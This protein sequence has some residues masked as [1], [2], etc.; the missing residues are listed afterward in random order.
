VKVFVGGNVVHT[1]QFFFPAAVTNA[2]ARRRPYS[3]HGRPDTPNAS[4]SIFRNGGS[5]SM[6]KLTRSGKGYVGAIS[7][8]VRR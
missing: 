8:G 7:M 4:D 6:L 5:R 1:G 3:R 2:V